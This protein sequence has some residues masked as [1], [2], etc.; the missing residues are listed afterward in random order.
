VEPRRGLESDAGPMIRQPELTRQSTKTLLRRTTVQPSRAK[1]NKL[2]DESEGSK[3]PS[4]RV[5]LFDE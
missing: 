4:D 3:A 5:E 1:V 2:E